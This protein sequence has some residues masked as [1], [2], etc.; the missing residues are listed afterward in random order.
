MIEKDKHNMDVVLC[1]RYKSMQ[2]LKEKKW[3][4]WFTAQTAEEKD[5]ED[6]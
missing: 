1:I 4:I 6:Q 5:F 3:Q 2:K